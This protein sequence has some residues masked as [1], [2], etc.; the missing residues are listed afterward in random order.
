MPHDSEASTGSAD[1][2]E[3]VRPH[4][5]FP[6]PVGQTWGVKKPKALILRAP[7]SAE[8]AEPVRPAWID[9]LLSSVEAAFALT[10]AT[11][12]GWPDPHPD[13]DP[14]EEEYSRC[15]DQGKYGILQTRLDAWRQALTAR[16]LVQVSEAS[17]TEWVGQVRPPQERPSELHFV[18][19]AAGGLSL[20][21][22]TTIV[23]DAP[24]GLD[25]GVR[26]AD[27]PSAYLA[28]LPDCGCDA[29][30]SGSADLLGQL[31]RHLLS[32][33][34]GGVIH[35]RLGAEFV[36]RNLDG[37][38]A[39]SKGKDSWLDPS[40]RAAKNVRRWSGTPWMDLTEGLRQAQPTC[41]PVPPAPP[42]P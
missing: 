16:G 27:H 19:T 26:S 1:L 17:A 4:V 5:G 33:A 6:L 11:T 10:G 41:P 13:R 7:G 28:S 9:E 30:D 32:I 31:D 14:L 36:T 29:C 34:Q 12:P 2:G 23:D 25:L 39:S 38:S 15:L 42:V 37:W 8:V 20:V 40:R 22:A 35:A 3:L 21:A 24:F 18:P